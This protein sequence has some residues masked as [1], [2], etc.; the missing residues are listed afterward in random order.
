MTTAP[1][2]TTSSD[3]LKCLAALWLP[4]NIW[5]MALPLAGF[6]TAGIA[7]SDVRF[8]I[9]AL[10]I[11]FIIAPMVMSFLYIYYMLTPEARRTVLTK[12]VEID[13]GKRLT[14]TYQPESDDDERPLPEPEVIEW[15]EIKSTVRAG[16]FLMYIL[17]GPGLRFLLVPCSALQNP[18]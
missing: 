12:T 17:N 10:V 7:L 1:F 18:N 5:W 8:M 6:I 13:P 11:L 15:S 3:Y 4:R 14:L 2:R 9:I 16:R